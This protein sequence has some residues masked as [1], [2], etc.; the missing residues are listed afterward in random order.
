MFMQSTE[1]ISTD[2]KCTTN[3][4]N[5]FL[6]CLNDSSY[7]IKKY[8]LKGLTVICQHQQVWVNIII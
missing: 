2:V 1:T 7:N 6:K 5:I 4:I 3:L 8:C